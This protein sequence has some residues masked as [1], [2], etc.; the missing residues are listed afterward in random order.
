ML[1]FVF[2][3]YAA[4]IKCEFVYF[5]YFNVYDNRCLYNAI[6]KCANKKCVYER[7]GMYETTGVV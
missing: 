4:T 5:V 7:S 3:S 6:K 1:I 2:I